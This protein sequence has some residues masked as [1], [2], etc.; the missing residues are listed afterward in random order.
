MADRLAVATQRPVSTDSGIGAEPAREPLSAGGRRTPDSPSSGRRGGSGAATP[1]T[2]KRSF[3]PP[4]V[5]LGV[6]LVA[7]CALAAVLWQRHTNTTETFV[8]AARPIARGTVVSAA[9]L[10]GAQIGGDTAA[11]VR[12]ADASSLLGQ[13]AAVDIA[14]GSPMSAALVT[15]E[16]PLAADEALTSMALEPGEMPPD[17][18][19]NDHV[20]VV[21]T[22]AADP[23]GASTTVLLDAT[24]IVWS[25]ELSQDGVSTV[26]TVRGP[27]SLSS[28]IASAVSV[29]LARVEG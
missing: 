21:V 23:T 28:D 11:L 1:A 26:V 22:T 25:V 27:L 16:V 24:A 20:R 13:I 2:K 29:R 17:L 12:G 19:P 3:R 6:L 9:D 7:G 18:A 10:G 4:E 15:A 8:V 14:V 5:V